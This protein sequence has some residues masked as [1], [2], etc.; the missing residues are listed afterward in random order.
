MYYIPPDKHVNKDFLQQ[1]LSNKKKL[2]KQ[3]QFKFIKVPK[4]DELS[5]KTF[6]ELSKIDEELVRYFPDAV[7]EQWLPDR[8]YFFNVLNTLY[9]DYLA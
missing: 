6:W 2:L 7:S 5:V 1:I 4:Y 8:D 3:N 9:P